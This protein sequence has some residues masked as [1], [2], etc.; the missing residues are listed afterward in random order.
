MFDIESM[1]DEIRDTLR[2][3]L[4]PESLDG[5]LETT[6]STDSNVIDV[7]QSFIPFSTLWENTIQA[8]Y[9][10][11]VSIKLRK[12]GTPDD[13][14]IL[15]L[16]EDS[17]SSPLGDTLATST[18]A[19]GDIGT[20]Q[21]SITSTLTVDDILVSKNVHWLKLEPQCSASTI[22]Y[23]SVVRDS[24]SPY[25]MGEASTFVTGGTWTT[26]DYDIYF[27][28]SLPGWIYGSYPYLEL[29]LKKYPRVAIEMV[30]R[31]RVD[32]RWIDERICQY[33]LDFDIVAVGRYKDEV[34]DI[35]SYVDRAL[36]IERIKMD[37]FRITNPGIISPLTVTRENLFR[38]STRV[39]C[40]YKHSLDVLA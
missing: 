9:T 22:N 13:D 3:Y 38:R 6:L 11:E 29:A 4:Y 14:V 24:N 18:I 21:T 10:I 37:S 33:I 16:V 25:L 39:R 8:Q 27:D 20:V 31:P 2:L 36:F 40:I 28:C 34:N 17:S 15:S 26:T 5:T 12:Y 19:V 30:G 1:Q 35:L 7:S 32:Q 23:Y